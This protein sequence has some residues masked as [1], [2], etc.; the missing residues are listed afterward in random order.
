M[1]LRIAC[2]GAIAAAAWLNPVRSAN[3]VPVCDA[4]R[5]KYEFSKPQNSKLLTSARGRWTR[6]P[7]EASLT[8]GRTA[9]V[10]ASITGS[11]T[12]EAGVIFAKAS[13]Q[14]GVTVGGSY[15]WQTSETWS[16]KVP[17]GHEARIVIY[18][19]SV[20][21]NVVKK[22]LTADCKYENAG[23]ATINTPVKPS[24][25]SR[26]H[27]VMQVRKPPKPYATETMSFREVPLKH[28]G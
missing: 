1:I 16:E 18:H 24:D 11:V 17:T 21:F 8:V 26:D 7:V 9:Q 15:A 28:N 6:A 10:N 25:R 4:P 5:V 2:I 14:L 3:A 19:D 27:V 20:A 23:H 12:A 22:Q 13:T